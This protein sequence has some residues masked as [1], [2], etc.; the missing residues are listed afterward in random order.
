MFEY[1]LMLIVSTYLL[2]AV[3]F[4]TVSNTRSLVVFKLAPSILSVLLFVFGAKSLG[5]L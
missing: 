3:T 4:T 2:V 1:I 5:W